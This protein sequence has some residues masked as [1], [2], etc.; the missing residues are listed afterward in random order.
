MPTTQQRIKQLET[1]CRRIAVTERNGLEQYADQDITNG[2][3]RLINN[4]EPKLTFSPDTHLTDAAITEE[5]QQ[6]I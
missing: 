1:W 6:F 5:L 4:E 3:L 2:M